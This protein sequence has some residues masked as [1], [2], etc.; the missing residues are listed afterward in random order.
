[1]SLCRR[2]L[3]FPLLE[4]VNDSSAAEPFFTLVVRFRFS[5]SFIHCFMEQ[6]KY[7]KH[8]QNEFEQER[9][10]EGKEPQGHKRITDPSTCSYTQESHENCKLEAII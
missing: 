8:Y 3:I 10:T 4:G 2:N 6:S 5:Q 1:M 9:H 7:N